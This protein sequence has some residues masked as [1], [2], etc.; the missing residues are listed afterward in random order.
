MTPSVAQSRQ[1]LSVAL[2]P[3]I[4]S[5]FYCVSTVTSPQL[6]WGMSPGLL[7]TPSGGANPGA[8]SGLRSGPSGTVIA[9]GTV[10]VQVDERTSQSQD[11]CWNSWKAAHSPTLRVRSRGAQRPPSDTMGSTCQR[12]TPSQEK[13]TSPE[14]KSS[15][16]HTLLKLVR[17]F[18]R[19]EIPATENQRSLQNYLSILV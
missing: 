14:P 1:H 4:Q 13:P 3:R 18:L 10:L 15:G 19:V 9:A 11:S 5:P 12:M 7:S 8:G 6:P 17:L 16:V 2:L